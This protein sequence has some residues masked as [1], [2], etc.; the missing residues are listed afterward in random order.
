MFFHFR[1]TPQIAG[2]GTVAQGFAR[3]QFT[4]GFDVDVILFPFHDRRVDKSCNGK[5][6]VHI[7]PNEKALFAIV[8]DS[9]AGDLRCRLA[10]VILGRFELAHVVLRQRC[11][12]R[13][14]QTDHRDGN[15]GLKHNARRLWVHV[16]I[17]LRRGRDVPS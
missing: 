15:A 2:I 16:N 4:C 11:L 7:W 5:R 6:V 3:S 10:D 9:I 17:E 8:I 12:A 13:D 14:V 1:A